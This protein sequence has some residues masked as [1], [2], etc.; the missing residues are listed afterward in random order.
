MSDTIDRIKLERTLDFVQGFI[1]PV[2]VVYE[3][4]VQTEAAVVGEESLR[5]I[6]SPVYVRI[7]NRNNLINVMV[8]KPGGV[9]DI[10]RT[11][12]A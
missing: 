3:E 9:N 4:T 5:S 11:E 10:P 1:L 8:V 2:T 12:T 6:R 7:E